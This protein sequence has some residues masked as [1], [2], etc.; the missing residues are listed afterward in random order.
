MV[1]GIKCIA[2]ESTCITER[3]YQTNS[4]FHRRLETEARSTSSARSDT[5][6]KPKLDYFS[7]GKELSAIT[8]TPNP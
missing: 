5:T 3:E 2:Y 7:T 1:K 6:P 8:H 4:M